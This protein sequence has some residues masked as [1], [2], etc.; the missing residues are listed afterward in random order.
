MIDLR[1]FEYV[2]DGQV[3]KGEIARP[4]GPGPHP[5]VLVM[6]HAIGL[7]SNEMRRTRMLAEA[8]YVALATD[9]YGIGK[10]AVSQDVYAPMF[11]ALQGEPDRLRGRVLAGYDALRALP[12]VDSARVSAIGFCFGGQCVL[13]LART[14]ADVASVVSFHGLLTTDRPAAKGAVKAKVLAITGALDP[15]AP[16]DHVAGFQAE[17]TAAEVDWQ[18]TVYGQGMH[19]FTDPSVAQHGVPGVRY[20]ALLD[21]LSWAQATA[22]LEA[23]L[24]PS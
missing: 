22:F 5:A 3:L 13:E 9:M 15:Y 19:A 6:H 21:R 23:T 17:M 24:Q 4:A 11:A 1:T 20:D 8:G 10:E 2:H 14:G 16:A 7:G 18:L 12:E